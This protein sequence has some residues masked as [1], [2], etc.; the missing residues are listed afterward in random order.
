MNWI[1]I[2]KE[3]GAAF[4]ADKAIRLSAALAYYSI[5]SMAPLLVVAIS[6]AGSVFG[7]KAALGVV[8]AELTGAIGQDAAATVQEMIVGVNR[9]GQSGMMAM[10]GFGILLLSA[11][12]V[13]AQLKD[14]MNTVWKIRPKPG[15]GLLVLVWDRLLSLTMVLVIG[16][17]LLVSL[18][19]SAVVSAAVLWLGELLPVHPSLVIGVNATVS[20]AVVTLLFATIF[21]VLPDAEIRWRDVWTGAFLT[22]CLFSLGKFLLAL[23][24]AQKGADSVYGA[25]GAL[26]LVLSWVY[27]SANI[28]LF[29]AEL[30]QVLARAKG[31]RIQPTAAGEWDVEMPGK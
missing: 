6:I 18:V 7:E 4:M 27:Y 12:G 8:E 11:S 19:L 20:L 14:A 23:Y 16:F 13:F 15:R 3:T 21:K 5:F 28:L 17:L 31:R 29:G 9:S 25:A 10:V 30:T 1:G 2:L 26:I 24:L 22:A